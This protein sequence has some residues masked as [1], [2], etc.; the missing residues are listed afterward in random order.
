MFFFLVSFSIGL[1]DSFQFWRQKSKIKNQNFVK[2]NCKNCKIDKIFLLKF[3]K[4]ENFI[5]KQIKFWK[6]FQK[7]RKVKRFVIS[8]FGLGG[9]DLF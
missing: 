9:I 4:I 7:K 3:N 2:F 5:Q 1:K 6:N 8:G